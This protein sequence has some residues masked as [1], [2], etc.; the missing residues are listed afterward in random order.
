MDRVVHDDKK[1]TVRRSGHIGMPAVQQ[2]GNVVVP[3]QENEFFLVNDN[4]KGIEEF[5]VKDRMTH[6]SESRA[7]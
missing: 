3:V 2:D 4:K 1:D 6:K 7:S 5:S